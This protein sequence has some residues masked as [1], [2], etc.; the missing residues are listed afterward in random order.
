MVVNATWAPEVTAGAIDWGMTSSVLVLIV[1]L[2]TPSL[3]DQSMV[4]VVS[5]PPSVGSSPGGEKE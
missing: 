2:S 1:E 4:R 3:T 5:E